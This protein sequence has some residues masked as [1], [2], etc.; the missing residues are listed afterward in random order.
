MLQTVAV[1]Q[2]RGCIQTQELYPRTGMYSGARLP[3]I[4]GPVPYNC[5]DTPHAVP[6][7]RPV[8][9][10]K[11]GGIQ[12]ATV[13]RQPTP[14]PHPS[15]GLDPTGHP[16]ARAAPCVRAAPSSPAAPLV[17]T[18]APGSAGL[19][20][21]AVKR[22]ALPQSRAAACR[23]LF[24][25][26]PYAA[27]AAPPL[28]RPLR[29]RRAPPRGPYSPSAVAPLARGRARARLGSYAVGAARAVRRW[30]SGGGEAS[31][32]GPG[33]PPWGSGRGAAAPPPGAEGPPR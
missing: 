1:P 17:P 26:A 7:T 12:V 6:R 31:G 3:H 21:A 29:L 30:R 23:P 28:S 22:A 27:A 4:L 24:P 14:E 13:A 25:N 16:T 32:A 18:A 9:H 19:T 2:N 20:G 8:P 5:A 10:P 11:D 33:A 15:V